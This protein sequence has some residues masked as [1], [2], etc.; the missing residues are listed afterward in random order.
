MT[1]N[2]DDMTNTVLQ[3]LESK[4][5]KNLDQWME[6]AN[7][8]PAMKHKEII[9]Y[10]KSEYDLTYGYANLIALKT[11]EAKEG[12]APSGD[13][14]I[15]AQY[16]GDK[17]EL[18]PIYDEIMANVGKFGEDVEIAPKKSY[19]SLRRN[20]Q[21]AIVQ[22]STKTRVDVGINLKGLDPG[23]RLE[24]SGNFNA[25]VS[26]RVRITELDQMDEELIDWL[27]EAYQA[28]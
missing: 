25:M 1:S 28:A 20:K 27:K 4:T 18:R 2:I 26:H 17:S 5:G 10:L 14:L 12:Q 24:T 22:P 19:V 6:I 8:S 23:D 13:A 9:D 16:S 7:N 21:F 3:N 15:E 11:R